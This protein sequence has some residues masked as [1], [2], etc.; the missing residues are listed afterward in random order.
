MA[1]LFVIVKGK[2]HALLLARIQRGQQRLRRGNPCGCLSAAVAVTASST[3]VI[4]PAISIVSTL[5]DPPGPPPGPIGHA[6]AR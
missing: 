4:A 3:L 6:H 2:E 5:L 1:S